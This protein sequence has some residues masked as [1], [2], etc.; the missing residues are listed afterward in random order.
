[1]ITY[2]IDL[3]I[4]DVCSKDNETPKAYRGKLSRFSEWLGSR[5]IQTLVEQDL[6]D[7]RG[8]LQNK[9]IKA[10]GKAQIKERLSPFTVRTVLVTVR[11]FL[12]WCHRRGHMASDLAS[13]WVIPSAPKPDPKAIQ[14]DVFEQLVLAACEVGEPWE[15]ARNLA[16]LYLLRDTGG[17]ISALLYA[18]LEDIDWPRTTINSWSKGKPYPLYLNPGSVETLRAWLAVRYVANPSDYKIFTG[19]KCSGLTRSGVYHILDRLAEARHVQGR[20]NPHAFRHAFARDALQAG[21]DLSQVAQLMVHSSIVVTA[22]YYA[23]WN[24]QELREA[25]RRFSPGRN[26]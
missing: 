23:R 25:H 2:L 26:L 7:F 6:E 16:L 17:R 20:H 18:E 8:Y 24:D 22:D 10:R 5:D 3:Y 9:K 4:T 1:M 15:R 12:R 13:R 21:A 14:P 11:G 19:A